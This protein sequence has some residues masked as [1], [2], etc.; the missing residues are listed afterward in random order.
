MHHS[1]SW[2]NCVTLLQ[3]TTQPE[4]MV[5]AIEILLVCRS[6]T[7]LICD[8]MDDGTIRLNHLEAP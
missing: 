6:V 8:K 3:S 7:I 1:Y 2:F 5:Y 4:I